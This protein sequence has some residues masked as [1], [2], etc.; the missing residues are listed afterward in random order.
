[1]L[2]VF[3]FKNKEFFEHYFF[4]LFFFL[5]FKFFCHVPIRKIFDYTA[6]EN[7]PSTLLI[8]FITFFRFHEKFPYLSRYWFFPIC[9]KRTYLLNKS[10]FGLIVQG[11]LYKDKNLFHVSQYTYTKNVSNTRYE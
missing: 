8:I 2:S 3:I 1:M 5:H 9:N 6:A 4:L 11:L 10:F 7:K